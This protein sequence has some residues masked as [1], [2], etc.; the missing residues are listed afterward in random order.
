MTSQ[1]LVEEENGIPI[2][3][4]QLTPS[5]LK[6][7]LACLRLNYHNPMEWSKTG[8]RYNKKTNIF[9]L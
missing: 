4:H 1:L 8:S 5:Q 6:E 2:E 7:H 3:N 9:K